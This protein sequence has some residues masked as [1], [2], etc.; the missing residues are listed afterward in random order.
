MTDLDPKLLEL[1]LASPFI[2]AA[3]GDTVIMAIEPPWSLGQVNAL[4]TYL[5]EWAPQVKWQALYEP[6]FTGV[7]H[8]K[9]PSREPLILPSMTE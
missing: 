4:G 7:I 2:T 1:L 9:A 6:G 5:M 8:I 3:G